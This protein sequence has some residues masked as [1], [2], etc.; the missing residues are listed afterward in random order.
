MRKKKTFWSERRVKKT[1]LSEGREA[2][3]KKSPL[4]C[5]DGPHRSPYQVQKPLTGF[6]P[7]AT[8]KKAPRGAPSLRGTWTADTR[9][10]SLH[11][12]H[13]RA[14]F[15]Y[16]ITTQDESLIYIYEYYFATT[17]NSSPW[18]EPLFFLT[19]TTTGHGK[20]PL[21]HAEVD[22]TGRYDRNWT[23]SEYRTDTP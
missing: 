2:C 16:R 20:L 17:S 6:H 23:S 4:W 19:S 11:S 12:P 10:G 5:T 1:Q 7:L 8:K 21:T 18:V 14:F 9:S 15:I 22:F 13:A 3:W